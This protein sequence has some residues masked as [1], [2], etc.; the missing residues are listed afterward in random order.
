MLYLCVYILPAAL[1]Q[2][3]LKQPAFY[4]AVKKRDPSLCSQSHL[5]C[6]VKIS[7]KKITGISPALLLKEITDTLVN[8]LKLFDLAHSFSI[9]RVEH[10][11]PSSAG[12]SIGD[13]GLGIITYSEF[14]Q[15]PHTG[16]SGIFLCRLNSLYPD[17]GGDNPAIK[18]IF[19]RFFCL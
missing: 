6:Q 18:R 4:P 1:V 5:L 11:S 15:M 17:I 14:N 9:F 7:R 19:C 8:N 3:I 13:W 10:Y 12:P 16:C 2:F